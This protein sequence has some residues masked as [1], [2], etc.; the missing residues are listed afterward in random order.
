MIVGRGSKKGESKKAAVLYARRGL[1]TIGLRSHG[2][3][4]VLSHLPAGSGEAAN[5][6]RRYMVRLPIFCAE[7]AEMLRSPRRL[8][9][10]SVWHGGVSE[11]NFGG[12]GNAR[13]VIKIR[14][15][16]ARP[17]SAALCGLCA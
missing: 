11:P 4:V 3:C 12:H 1:L 5:R 2:V 10:A 6:R 13:W 16:G 9:L 7:N 14:A 8:L 15:A 17:Y